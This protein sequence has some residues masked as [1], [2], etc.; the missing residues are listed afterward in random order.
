[1]SEPTEIGSSWTLSLHSLTGS[2]R[3]RPESMLQLQV[4]CT[5]QHITEA[6][7]TVNKYLVLTTN[8]GAA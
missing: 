2:G 7:R 3:K 1:V 8:E 5:G 4:D 6:Q